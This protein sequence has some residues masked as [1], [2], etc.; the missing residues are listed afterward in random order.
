MKKDIGLI[1]REL[2]K[3]ALD[4]AIVSNQTPFQVLIATVLSQRTKDANTGKAAKALFSH[5]KT[6]KAL[7]K[8]P[9]QE[10]EKLV[11]AAGFFRVKAKRIK[12]ISQIIDE[13]YNGKLPCDRLQLDALPGVG[14]KTSACTMVYGFKKP[15]ICVDVHVHGI[16]NRLGLVNTKTPEETEAEL[17]KLVPKKYWLKLNHSMVRFGQKICLPRNPRHEKCALKKQCDFFQGKG[18]WKK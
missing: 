13:K 5:Y 1:M 12:E 10:I 14:P 8:A 7:S 16:S 17:T 6:P 15:A 9:L 18:Q 2:S 3:L 4:N 11:K